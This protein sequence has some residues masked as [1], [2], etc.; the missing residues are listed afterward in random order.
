[1]PGTTLHRQRSHRVHKG[2]TLLD[3]L[4]AISV[5]AILLALL[6]PT[7][8]MVTENARRIVCASGLQQTGVALSGW[9]ND[10]NG[11]LPPVAYSDDYSVEQTPKRLQLAFLD[12][13]YGEWDGLGLLVSEGYLSTP[14]MFYC[15]SHNGENGF[16]NYERDWTFPDGEIVTNYHYRWL[17]RGNRFLDNLNSDVTLVSDGIRTKLDY[18]HRVGNNMLK[19]DFHVD[20]LDDPEMVIVGLLPKS[21]DGPD[22]Q[23]LDVASVE[24]ALD[25]GDVGQATSNNGREKDNRLNAGEK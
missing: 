5:I 15:P 8:S 22:A 17:E 16:G 21:T 7:L 10:H 13:E 14:S 9:A 3:V 19:A 2:F 12:N 20:W 11:M 23:S 6:S 18:N 25:R 4:V 24:Y 1:M